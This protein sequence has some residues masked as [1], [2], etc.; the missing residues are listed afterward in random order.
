M[1]PDCKVLA[2]IVFLLYCRGTGVILSQSRNNQREHAT[3]LQSPRPNR[4]LAL[5][6][7]NR[8]HPAAKPKQSKGTCNRTAKSSPQSSSCS[9]AAEVGSS[10]R[11]AKTIKGNPVTVSPQ[12]ILHVVQPGLQ[13]RPVVANH[14]SL[15]LQITGAQSSG[16]SSSASSQA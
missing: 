2:P 10:C 1:Q 3:D 16:H 15:Q 11:K 6:L 12:P 9:I 4:L 7:R 8:C 14:D 13:L 5:V